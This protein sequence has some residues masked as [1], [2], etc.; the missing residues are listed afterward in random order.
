MIVSTY[1]VFE[2][3]EHGLS[4]SLHPR[5]LRLIIVIFM[6]AQVRYLL[7]LLRQRRHGVEEEAERD[8]ETASGTIARVLVGTRIVGGNKETVASVRLFIPD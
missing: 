7:R 2:M 4:I 3:P 5:T 8:V 1:V 6:V